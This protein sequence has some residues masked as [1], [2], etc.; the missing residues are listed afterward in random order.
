MRQDKNTKSTAL[1]FPTGAGVA[2]SDFESSFLLVIAQ[3]NNVPLDGN[4]DFLPGGDFTLTID[5]PFQF[6][7]IQ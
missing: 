5:V 7:F 1:A 6:F 2:A 3:D 4:F